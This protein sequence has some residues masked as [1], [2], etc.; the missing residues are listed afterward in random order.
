MP[1]ISVSRNLQP[2]VLAELAREPYLSK[3]AIRLKL[4]KKVF[5]AAFSRAD[6]MIFLTEHA[7]DTI[8]ASGAKVDNYKIIPH[9]ISED[10]RREPAQKKLPAKPVILYVSDFYVYK[11][12]W[13]VLRAVNLLRENTGIELQLHFVGGVAGIGKTLFEKALS[14]VKDHSW[15]HLKGR[16]PYEQ[17]QHHTC[18]K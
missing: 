13:E 5:N 4:L 1:H 12:Q 6:G 18:P 7:K 3:A 15:I 14:E 8:I 9:G 16:I 2:Y 17:I 11:Y 10:F